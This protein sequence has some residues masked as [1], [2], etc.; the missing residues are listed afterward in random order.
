MLTNLCQ[1]MPAC[2]KRI[3]PMPNLPLAYISVYQCMPA[4]LKRIQPMP[5]LPLAYVSVYQCMPASLKRIQ[6]MPILPLAYVSVY[7]CMPASLKRIQPMPILP[8]A[9]YVSVYQRT[10]E[11]F[12]RNSYVSLIRNSVTGSYVT[13]MGTG[14]GCWRKQPRGRG[15]GVSQDRMRCSGDTPTEG[16]VRTP[17]VRKFG[18]FRKEGRK[19]FI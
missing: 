10:S 5:N 7:Q 15:P 12:I 9:Y 6:P 17:P 18:H 14:N 11:N 3:Q 4:S 16:S 1:R 2:L 13:V 19:C 8:L